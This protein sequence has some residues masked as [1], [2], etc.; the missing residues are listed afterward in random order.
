MRIYKRESKQFYWIEWRDSFHRKSDSTCRNIK[1]VVS[2]RRLDRQK[3]RPAAA[4]QVA[5]PVATANQTFFRDQICRRIKTIARHRNRVMTTVLEGPV[6]RTRQAIVQ[7]S[8]TALVVPD[9]LVKPVQIRLVSK[10]AQMPAHCPEKG[11]HHIP[12]HVNRKHRHR[13][14]QQERLHANKQSQKDVAILWCDKFVCCK[15]LWIFSS[16]GLHSTGAWFISI[17]KKCELWQNH[18]VCVIHYFFYTFCGAVYIDSKCESTL[19]FIGTIFYL[20]CRLVRETMQR[21]VTFAPHEDFRITADA[22]KALQTSAEAFL[23]GTMEDAS[24]CAYHR[25]RV[26]LHPKDIILVRML[27]RDPELNRQ[28]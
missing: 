6:P 18:K 15:T 19:I 7:T 2:N 3:P 22:L 11:S 13:K 21:E 9:H 10:R 16:R 12:L 8:T 25:Q 1:A 20:F 4:T 23:V 17:V 5:P 26:T 14:R 27:R 28:N 24:F